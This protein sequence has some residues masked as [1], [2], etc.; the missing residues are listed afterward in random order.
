MLK[1]RLTLCEHT[2]ER[3][4]KPMSNPTKKL[5]RI[6]RLLVTL[7]YFVALVNWAMPL[8]L[9]TVGVFPILLAIT[10]IVSSFFVCDFLRNLGLYIIKMH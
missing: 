6:Q 3:A 7:C 9:G 1:D 5:Y 8:R 4:F 2:D 10:V